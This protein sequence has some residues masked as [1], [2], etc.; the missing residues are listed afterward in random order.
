MVPAGPV[1]SMAI[2]KETSTAGSDLIPVQVK[3][4]WGYAHS[5]T[6]SQL[7]IR[8][9]FTHATPFVERLAAVAAG[10]KWGYIDASGAFRIP[11]QF[12]SAEPFAG[13]VAKVTT[14]DGK[15]IRYI[16]PVGAFLTGRAALLQNSRQPGLPAGDLPAGMCPSAPR[17]FPATKAGAPNGPETACR[18]WSA[19]ACRC[20]RE[21]AR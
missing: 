19:D 4:L 3:G 16:D 15:Q 18:R 10:G 14:G 17:T 5:Q 13:G 6:P 21:L 8:P 2:G 11:A 1:R 12:N 9:Q 20:P 7:A